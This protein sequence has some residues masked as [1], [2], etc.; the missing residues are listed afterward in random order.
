GTIRADDR[1]SNEFPSVGVTRQ[2]RCCEM[3]KL[4]LASLLGTL[5][6]CHGTG[7]SFASHAPDAR[8]EPLLKL[9]THLPAD[10]PQR[11]LG[12]AYDGQK[13][14]VPI[15]LG[16]GRYATL[17]PSSLE[18]TIDD[19]RKAH[20]AIGEVSGAFESPGA[21]CFANGKLWVAG[22]YGDSFG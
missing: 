8:R 4:L 15:Y 22:S 19:T 2:L 12:L 18:W 7:L 16:R 20:F 11:V 13:L 14:W 6:I 21:I 10:L 1:E 3:R 5:I 17:D 9:V